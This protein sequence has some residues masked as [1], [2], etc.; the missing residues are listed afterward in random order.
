[1]SSSASTWPTFTGELKSTKTLRTVPDNSLETSTW[2]V[3][4]TE[5][6]AVMMTVR[7]TRLAGSTTKRLLGTRAAPE[8]DENDKQ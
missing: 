5:P 2:L 3:G 8:N 4:C 1:M 6:V 7:S